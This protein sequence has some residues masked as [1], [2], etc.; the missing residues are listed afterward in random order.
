MVEVKEPDARRNKQ[1]CVDGDLCVET[2]RDFLLLY[3]TKK[4]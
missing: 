2:K 4:Y 3:L 1:W